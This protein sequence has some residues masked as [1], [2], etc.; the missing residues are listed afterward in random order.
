MKFIIHDLEDDKPLEDAQ[1]TIYPTSQI[2]NNNCDE[3]IWKTHD[4]QADFMIKTGKDGK[5]RTDIYFVNPTNSNPAAALTFSVYVKK[6]GYN[7][8]CRSLSFVNAAAVNS[9]GEIDIGIGKELKKGETRVVLT[10]DLYAGTI[11]PTDAQKP[12]DLDLW[13]TFGQYVPSGTI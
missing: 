2:F 8:G 3:S 13:T 10:W 4:V 5:A 12:F 6:D 11:S 1:L 7:I 9:H